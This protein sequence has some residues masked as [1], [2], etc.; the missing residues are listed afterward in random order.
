MNI[1]NPSLKAIEFALAITTPSDHRSPY[2]SEVAVQP[3]LAQ[4]RGKCGQ[5][6]HQKA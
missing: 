5:Q 3:L 4:H 6:R 2:V 1:W